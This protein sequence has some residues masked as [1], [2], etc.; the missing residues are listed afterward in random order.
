M[1]CFYQDKNG[2]IRSRQNRRKLQREAE[3]NNNKLALI[4][5]DYEKNT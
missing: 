4:I 2:K 3:K 1:T 5:E